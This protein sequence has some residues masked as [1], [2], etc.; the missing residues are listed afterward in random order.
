MVSM[1]DP[2]DGLVSYRE[3]L[4][5]GLIRPQLGRAHAELTVLLDDAEG[6]KRLT[7]ALMQDGEVL[8]IAIYVMNGYEYEKPCFQ[9]GYAVFDKFRNQGVAKELLKMSL[10]ELSSE[11]KDI[12]PSFHIE[13]VVSPSNVASKKVAEAIIGGTPDE[14]TDKHS[15]EN[16]HRY[17]KTVTWR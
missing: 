11:F 16:A 5:K 3:A 9:V 6:E 1:V 12:F 2:H 17:T 13:A 10:D 4:S 14:I 8:G 15:G 7:Y